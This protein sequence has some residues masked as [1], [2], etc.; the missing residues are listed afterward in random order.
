MAILLTGVGVGVAVCAAAAA[1]PVPA[2]DGPKRELVR[3]T[4]TPAFDG[5][6][7]ELC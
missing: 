6:D 2:L 3:A 5:A 1:A 4:W 7:A